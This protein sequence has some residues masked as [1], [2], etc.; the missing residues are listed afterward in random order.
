MQSF[1][2]NYRLFGENE[3]LEL[4]ISS[5]LG[6]RDQQQ[7]SAGFELNRDEALVLVCDGMGGHAGGQRA[8]RLAVSLLLKTYREEYPCPDPHSWLVDLA[9]EADY[10]V[11]ALKDESGQLLR[12]GSTVVAVLIRGRQLYWLSVGDSRIYLY[13]DGELVRATT[14]HNYQLVLQ[15]QLE[16]GEIDEA[17]FRAQSKKG[18][19]LVSFLGVNGL[20]IVASNERP[21]ELRSGDMVLLTSDGLY[22][23]LSDENM[24]QILQNFV[25]VPDALTALEARASSCG[26]N[27]VRDNMTVSI[28]KIK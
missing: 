19:A 13:R 16:S 20:P 25:K 2:D 22:R 7:D 1:E 21:F 17:A 15:A 3:Y 27:K 26:K 24:E 28:I 6:N 11:A 8:S 9:A 14:D 23:L 18:E 12:A 10:A 5:V 4:G